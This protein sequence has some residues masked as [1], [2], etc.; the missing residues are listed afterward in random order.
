M[1]KKGS[2]ALSI[3]V[4]TIAV[5]L[6]SALFIPQVTNVI[7]SNPY[8]DTYLKTI[9]D[10]NETTTLTYTNI[11]YITSVTN[12]TIVLTEGNNYTITSGVITFLGGQ[13]TSDALSY[14]V[15]YNYFNR[16]YSLSAGEIALFSVVILGGIIGLIYALFKM[17]GLSGE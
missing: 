14:T 12:G 7:R 8:S 3:I 16:S 6:L 10:A 1:N 13:K 17:F 4:L 11:D 15:A 2:L 5:V 9:A